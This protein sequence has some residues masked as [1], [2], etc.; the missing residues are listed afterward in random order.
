MAKTSILKA[1]KDF[2]KRELYTLTAGSATRPM[3]DALESVLA[4]KDWVLYEY[5]YT[6]ET[7]EETIR[8]A[9]TMVTD[10]GEIF[11]SS[12]KPFVESFEEIID[13]LDGDDVGGLVV[14]EKESRNNR[15]YLTCTLAI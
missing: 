7:G 15:K 4:V 5:P 13:F 3:R 11:G 6:E 12:A 2:T 14:V 9:V 8:K 1:S 10:D